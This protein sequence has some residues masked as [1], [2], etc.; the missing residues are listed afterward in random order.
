MRDRFIERLMLMAKEDP[1]ITLIT[2]D[3]GFG[4]LTRFA[5][6]FPRQFINAGVAEQ[7]MTGLATGMALEGR[8]TFTYSIANFAT[9]RCLEQIRNDAA[10]HGA[11][12]NVVSIGGG[13]SYGPLG[14]SHHATE[15]LSIM[16]AL[17]DVT[18]MAP[19]CLWE[20]HEAPALLAE[21]PGTT[22]LRLDK[23]GPQSTR[24]EGESLVLGRGRVIR[25]G[26]DISLVTCG[27]I[28]EEVLD[29][30]DALESGGVHCRVISLHT[31]RPLDRSILIAAARETGGIVSIEENTICGGLGGLIAETLLEEGSIPRRFARVGLRA[32]FSSIV[33]SQKYLRKRYGLDSASI[34][35]K[36]RE[37]LSDRERSEGR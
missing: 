33:G 17:P 12:V 10:Y 4:V 7:N 25:P 6:E 37:L 9:L 5:E 26:S 21:V 13:F 11:N 30:A 20:A 14:I 35:G 23:S 28:L 15:D 8:I 3:L 29:A 36:V 24:R 1:R 19:S 22:Y 18:V 34:V 32:G 16:R 2:G 27:G 31:L